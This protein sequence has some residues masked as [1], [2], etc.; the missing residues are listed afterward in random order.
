MS[1]TG[2]EKVT[3]GV[4]NP[5]DL[6]PPYSDPVQPPRH[7]TAPGAYEAHPP[8]P[9]QLYYGMAVQDPKE[10]PV[11]QPVEL[12]NEPDHLAY[13]IFTML[14]CCL[15]LGVAALVYS[16]LT[17]EANHEGNSTAAQRNSRLARILAH[18]ALGV[19]ICVLIIYIIFI[20]VMRVALK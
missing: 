9:N 4:P 2:Y 17:R 15:P 20:V 1:N 14:C 5:Q 10:E 19:G 6:P 3:G 11:R 7:P 13:A 18:S 12:T 16:I 8:M